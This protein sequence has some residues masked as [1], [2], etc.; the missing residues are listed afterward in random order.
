MVGFD[1]S[2]D[3]ESS[4]MYRWRVPEVRSLRVML[5]SQRLWPSV[6]V[7]A[8]GGVYVAGGLAQRILSVAAQPRQLFLSAF[9]TKR[10][11]SVTRPRASPP[12][13]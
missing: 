5:S 13:P 6:T 8:T 3:I 1:V 9:V 4:R 7:L 10:P 2:P 11:Q 12:D